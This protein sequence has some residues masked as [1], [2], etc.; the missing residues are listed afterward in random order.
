MFVYGVLPI[1]EAAADEKRR[2]STY[3]FRMSISAFRRN[4]RLIVYETARDKRIQMKEADDGR[5]HHRVVVV[6]VRLFR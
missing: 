5:S 1:A 6:S 4:C 2:S 3:Y